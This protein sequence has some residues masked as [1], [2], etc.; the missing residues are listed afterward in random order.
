VRIGLEVC[1]VAELRTGVGQFVA[2]WLSA[3]VEHRE[4]EFLVFSDR[5]LDERFGPVPNGRV[6]P[7]HSRAGRWVWMQTTLPRALARTGPDLCHFTNAVAPLH[8]RRPF[9]LTVHDVSPLLHPE[10]HPL[11]RRAVWRTVVPALAARAD[12]VITGSH[13]ARADL[14]RVLPVA[15]ERVHVVPGAPPPGMAR[16]S[17][18][19]TLSAVR[20][21]YGLP[22]EFVL[23]VGT[24]EPR[25]NL[26]RLVRA[27]GRVRRLGHPHGLV[28]V[29]PRG[30]RLPDL[31]GQI[32]R[33]G[34]TGAVT[35]CG[36]VPDRDLAAILSLATTL[37]YPSLYE[38]F[39]L[40]PLEAMACG[41]PV[42]AGDRGAVPE[43]CGDAA[44]LVDP[45][46]EV[47]LAAALAAMLSNED[48]RRDLARRGL[49][50]AGNFSWERSAE[51]T[52]AVYAKALG[53]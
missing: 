53:A 26:A 5:P 2:R 32:E 27:M 29:G 21:R 8:P 40:P 31:A 37:A 6:V 20:T 23:H 14:L 46:D 34:L 9:V 25:K 35:F 16:V 28:L 30:W 38:G 18:E 24:L 44:L 10:H 3:L 48:L 45:T 39:G 13:A 17:D 1:A 36:Y 51:R 19:A 50:R 43:V 33:A 7:A 22:S 11:G 49:E 42:V 12:A 4:H 52:L 15:P 47:A 41:T